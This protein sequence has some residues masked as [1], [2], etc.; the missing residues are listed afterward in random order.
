MSTN[1]VINFVDAVAVYNGYPAL[2]GV[3]IRVER[4][5]IVLLQ[6]PNGAGKSTLLRACA[7]LIPVIRGTANVLGHDLTIDRESVRERVGLLGHQNGLFGELTIEENVS[8]WSTVVGAST[9]E[10]NSAMER[11][12]IDGKLAGR[13]VS[14]LSAGQKRRCALA[15]LVVRRAELWLLDEPHAGLDAKGRD[16]IDRIVKEATASGATIVVASHEIERAQ[17][18]ATRTISLVSGQVRDSQ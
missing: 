8:F 5:E 7:G 4:N 2:A 14:E 10:R 6:G 15:C 16:E 13:R 12:A 1:S 9:E 3:T 18:L 17:Q 11:M